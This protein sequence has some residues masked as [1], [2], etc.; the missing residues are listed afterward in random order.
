M[1]NAT[2]WSTLTALLAWS[3][4]GHA[5]EPDKQAQLDPLSSTQGQAA[6]TTPS[7]LST[8]SIQ[9]GTSDTKA[10]VSLA[11]FTPKAFLGD[12]SLIQIGGEAPVSK[13][14]STST[15]TDIG[16]VSGLTAGASAS[17]GISAFWWPH[18]PKSLTDALT[19][20]C[21]VEFPKLIIGFPFNVGPASHQRVS[22][23]P[24]LF[25][26]KNLQNIA[27]GFNTII[28]QCKNYVDQRKRP[29]AK[30]ILN[31]D[32]TFPATQSDC[33]ELQTLPNQAKLSDQATDQAYLQGIVNR[34]HQLENMAS[35]VKVLTLGT[36]VNR[37]KVAYFNKGE[38][39]TLIND[40]AT[41]YGANLTL[42][43]IKQ[44]Y[45][46]SGGLSYEKTFKSASAVQ[47]CSPVSGSMST[48]CLTGTIGEPP[49]TYARIAFTE[50]R[51]LLIAH[52]LAIAPR[53]EYDFT[54]SKFAA[55]LPIYLAPDKNK[56]LT[57]G[58]TLGYVTHGQGFGAAVFVGKAFSFF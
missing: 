53:A 34:A 19:T 14:A 16:T 13:D 21:E 9:A 38:L 33:D 52:S 47:I 15:E 43:V 27:E 20:I 54:A 12:Y 40:H 41:A 26:A 10:T 1:M 48:E 7:S 56:T 32:G 35:A 22:C 2:R 29:P 3:L 4:V 58:L 51:V 57:G 17:A 55:R 50:A 46:I 30:P 28:A 31:K 18:Q 37:Q 44:S 39:S 36:T 6:A 25:G 23:D 45:L 49:G 11:G 42:S 8:L 24:S 5:I